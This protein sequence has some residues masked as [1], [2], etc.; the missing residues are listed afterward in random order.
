MSTL[1]KY[2]NELELLTAE[3]VRSIDQIEYEQ[4]AAFSE[5]REQLVFSIESQKGLLTTE[6]KLRLRKL[7][8]FDEIILSKMEYYRQNASDWLEKQGAIKVQKNAYT[9]QYAANSLFFDQKN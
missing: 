6:Y 9:S 1:G 3:I 8:E 2:I 4:L 5:Q 7:S